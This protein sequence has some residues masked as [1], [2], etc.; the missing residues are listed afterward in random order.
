MTN[1]IFCA[2]RITIIA[3]E[4]FAKVPLTPYQKYIHKYSFINTFINTL[5][6][7]R[8]EILVRSKRKLKIYSTKAER[9][10]FAPPY[11]A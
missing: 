11:V 9:K 8:K 4:N 1:F 3:F 7:F 10:M 5:F 6:P 2:V